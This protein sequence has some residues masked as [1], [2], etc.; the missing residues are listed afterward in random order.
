MAGWNSAVSIITLLHPLAALCP[1]KDDDLLSHHLNTQLTKSHF[2][3][4]SFGERSSYF[5]DFMASLDGTVCQ[6]IMI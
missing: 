5:D 1:V 3:E 4:Q 6:H 2:A